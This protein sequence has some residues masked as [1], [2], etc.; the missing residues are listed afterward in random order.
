VISD[1]RT[2]TIEIHTKITVSHHAAIWRIFS[3]FCH[4]VGRFH[5]SKTPN[6]TRKTCKLWW[7]NGLIPLSFCPSITFVFDVMCFCRL[8]AKSLMKGHIRKYLYLHLSIILYGYLWNIFSLFVCT[9][10]YMVKLF[11]FKY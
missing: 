10:Y 4:L 7:N 11:N 5:A 9:V 2:F 6:T 3:R 1:Y 8:I